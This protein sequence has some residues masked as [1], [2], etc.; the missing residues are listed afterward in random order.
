MPMFG[1][2]RAASPM[3]GGYDQGGLDANRRAASRQFWDTINRNKMADA[4]SLWGGIRGASEAKAA[5]LG[6]SPYDP[7]ATEASQDAARAKRAKDYWRNPGPLDNAG[8]ERLSPYQVPAGKYGAGNL[9]R[10]YPTDQPFSAGNGDYGSL[11]NRARNGY[12]LNNSER[13]ALVGRYGQNLNQFLDSPGAGAGQRMG[14]WSRRTDRLKQ[15]VSALGGGAVEDV[16]GAT[17]PVSTGGAPGGVAGPASVALPPSAVAPGY[18]SLSGNA[19]VDQFLSGKEYI[20]NRA[21][22]RRAERQ[23]RMAGMNPVMARLMAMSEQDAGRAFLASLG[24]NNQALTDARNAGVMNANNQQYATS[25]QQAVGMGSLGVQDASRRDGYDL[26]S[27][28]LEMRQ[29][30]ME[31]QQKMQEAVLGFLGVGSGVPGAT[32]TQQAG[33]TPWHP[34]MAPVGQSPSS[35][36]M[37][38]TV[39]SPGAGQIDPVMRTG[40]AMSLINPAVGAAMIEAAGN[41]ARYANQPTAQDQLLGIV[42]N[43]PN[44]RESLD[45]LRQTGRLAGQEVTAPAPSAP[46][47]AQGNPDYSDEYIYD[48][49]ARQP[50][51][52][53]PQQKMDALMAAGVPRS[54][55]EEMYDNSGA[56]LWDRINNAM[57]WAW[58]P[59]FDRNARVNR[60]NRANNLRYQLGG[61]L[62]DQQ[63]A[64]SRYNAGRAFQ[65]WLWRGQSR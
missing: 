22:A 52:A 60:M 10:A 5:G 21:Q 58:I 24:L 40:M 31:A 63:E 51:D 49:L 28:E 17:V 27:R 23:N 29:K 55:L 53:T 30:Q 25:A 7:A 56:G 14:D 35:D 47:D 33:N 36:P 61:M 9:A 11:L 41:A 38:Q 37:Q 8:M 50:A 2:N 54:R 26:G 34:P 16:A 48:L 45:V 46:R 43:S 39:A 62:G 59:D 44:P 19:A 12:Y 57:S 65:D 1:M 64:P 18:Q 3:R 6:M 13:E 4:D 32:P 42:M 20:Q 15:M